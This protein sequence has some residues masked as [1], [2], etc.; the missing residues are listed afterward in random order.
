MSTEITFTIEPEECRL[1][2]HW[3]STQA[4]IEVTAS[5]GEYGELDSYVV[6]GITSEGR[7]VDP[8]H[9][10]Y[11]L[12]V[13]WLAADF[14]DLAGKAVEAAEADGVSF[15]DWHSDLSADYRASVL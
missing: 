8:H 10:L 13:K 3:F 9:P 7:N 5:L 1:D 6:E 11:M 15:R 2:G 4:I 14:N 12:L